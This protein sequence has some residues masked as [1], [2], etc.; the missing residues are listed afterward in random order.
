[1]EQA[2]VYEAGG[3]G[4]NEFVYIL[5]YSSTYGLSK[6]NLPLWFGHQAREHRGPSAAAAARADAT[7]PAGTRPAGT[8]LGR[9]PT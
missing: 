1:M 3:A 6:S 8:R 9:A 5:N 7:S 4:E 2:E